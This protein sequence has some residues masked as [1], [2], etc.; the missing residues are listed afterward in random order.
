MKSKKLNKIKYS[1]ILLP[2]IGSHHETSMSPYSGQVQSSFIKTDIYTTGMFAD[3]DNFEIFGCKNVQDFID[4]KWHSYAFIFH[5]IN[6]I[7]VIAYLVVLFY[8]VIH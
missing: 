5:F 7:F 2:V 4:F 3:S 1:V 8:Y 6:I